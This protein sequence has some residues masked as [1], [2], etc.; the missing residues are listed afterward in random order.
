MKVLIKGVPVRAA[1]AADSVHIAAFYKG[2]R[3][4]IALK[5]LR[6]EFRGI[7][8]QDNKF[9]RIP[10]ENCESINYS[11]LDEDKEFLEKR[12]G[13]SKIKDLISKRINGVEC[14]NAIDNLIQS[15]EIIDNHIKYDQNSW[16]MK[17]DCAFGPLG[18]KIRFAFIDSDCYKDAYV[19]DM[20]KMIPDK[21]IEVYCED[22]LSEYRA[23]QEFIFN[24]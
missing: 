23:Q 3:N 7:I 10:L 22:Y 20:L 14:G 24:V 6:F 1:Y 12:F 2:K 4:A 5:N 9:Y 13:N 15:K 8:T 21:E 17:N 11:I 18:E 19:L 16:Y